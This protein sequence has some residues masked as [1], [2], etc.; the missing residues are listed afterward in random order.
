MNHIRRGLIAAVLL[1]AF[2]AAPAHAAPTV[3]IRIEGEQGT[4]LE[5]TTVTLD[6]AQVE[7]VSDEC[8]GDTVAGAIEAGTKGEWDRQPYAKTILGET[9]QFERDDAWSAWILNTDTL[10]DAI[11]AQKLQEGDE[12]V[13]NANFAPESNGYR[14]VYQPLTLHDVPA[15]VERGVPFTVRVSEIVPDRAPE[16]Y[17]LPG[18]GERVA[19]AGVRVAGGGASG[20]TGDDGRVELV[21]NDAGDFTLLAESGAGLDRSLR[22]P[23][24]VVEPGSP[25]PPPPPAEPQPGATPPPCFTDGA[26]GR[27]GTVDR[28]APVAL[29]TS[30]SEG[31][32]FGRRSGPRDLRGTAG[33]LGPRGLEP[34]GTGILMVKLRLTRRVGPRCS[35]WS[36]NRERFV[37]RPCGA[38]NGFF[39]RVGETPDWEYVLPAALGRGRYVLDADAIDRNGNRLR[40][41]RRGENRVVFRVR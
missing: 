18:R 38:E 23:I 24:R 27:C 4:L 22:V 6:P 5:R 31:A 21:L 12:V 3:T 19:S 16:G 33:I 1:V 25:P 2:A 26:D 15:Q 8:P 17:E 32:V 7:G 35:T 36:P 11:C 13:V 39:W 40:E 37:P 34:D 20:T 28:Q 14:W 29:I 41:R 10:S 30:I 9:H